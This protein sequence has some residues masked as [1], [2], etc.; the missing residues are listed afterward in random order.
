[1]LRGLGRTYG[2]DCAEYNDG[3]DEGC[4]VEEG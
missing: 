3:G 1:V 4:E 2:A